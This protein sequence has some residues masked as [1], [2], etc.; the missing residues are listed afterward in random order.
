MEPIRTQKGKLF[1]NLDI[2]A[3]VLHIKDGSN[4]RLIKVPKEGLELQFVSGN[5]Q[6]ETI[7]IPPKTMFVGI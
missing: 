5:G 2:S 1:G 6:A 7:Y 4:M 3:Y